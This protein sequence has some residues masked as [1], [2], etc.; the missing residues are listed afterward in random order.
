V[1]SG[2]G[3]DRLPGGVTD[4]GQLLFSAGFRA[5]DPA[6]AGTTITN[7]HLTTRSWNGRNAR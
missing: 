2:T 4:S 1:K 7:A 6:A 3:N 5:H